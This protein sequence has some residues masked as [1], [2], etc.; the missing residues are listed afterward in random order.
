MDTE[1]REGAWRCASDGALPARARRRM[2][3]EVGFGQMEDATDLRVAVTEARAT[4]SIEHLRTVAL[5]ILNAIPTVG[6]SLAAVLESMPADRERRLTELLVLFADQLMDVA[7]RIDSGFVRSEEFSARF[8]ETLERSVRRR[9]SEKRD[10]YAAL[11]ANAAMPDRPGQEEWYRMI[12]A[13]EAL[14]PWHLRVLWAVASHHVPSDQVTPRWIGEALQ[15]TLADFSKEEIEEAGADLAAQ[16]ILRTAVAFDIGVAV[17]PSLTPF[18]ER[19]VAFV[20]S[21]SERLE[22]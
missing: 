15:A 6:G 4:T 21:P 17:D 13:L 11:L 7:D 12:D 8:E 9:E 3:A 22:R 1:G 5:T 14:R 20:T 18:G 19:F 2:P 10:Y 16:H